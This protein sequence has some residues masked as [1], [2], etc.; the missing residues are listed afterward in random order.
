MTE[1]E[2]GIANV[3]WRGSDAWK[4]YLDTR[5]GL[6]RLTTNQKRP[7]PSTRPTMDV[8]EPSPSV[9]LLPPLGEIPPPAV[10][11][12]YAP[13]RGKATPLVIDNG[14]STVRFGFAGEAAPRMGPNTVSKYK[15]R[16]TNRPMLVFGDAVEVESAA[17]TQIRTPW[18]GD[19][20]LN[21]DALV[22]TICI[23]AICVLRDMGRHRKTCSI[24]RS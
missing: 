16:K 8:D 18:E 2:K 21:F 23:F 15:E 7:R 11:E 4:K 17:K 5:L 22:I 6:A 12:D 9:T 3:E 1:G 13:H 24:M 10:P 14:A 20:L 19:V